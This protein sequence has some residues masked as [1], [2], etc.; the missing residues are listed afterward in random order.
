MIDEEAEEWL[1]SEDDVEEV[2]EPGVEGRLDSEAAD[3]DLP[4]QLIRRCLAGIA[5]GTELLLPSLPVLAVLTLLP[6]SDNLGRELLP[7]AFFLSLACTSLLTNAKPAMC[8]EERIRLAGL[9]LC[10]S[11]NAVPGEWAS[12]LG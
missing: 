9:G 7:A 10:E 2:G 8:G 6:T 4:A 1:D 5:G 11:A 3:G 12:R